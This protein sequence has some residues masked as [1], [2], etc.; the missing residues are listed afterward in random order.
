MTHQLSHKIETYQLKGLV[1]DGTLAH[2][3]INILGK[4]G[5]HFEL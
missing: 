1:E 4:G 2:H 5:S 3:P